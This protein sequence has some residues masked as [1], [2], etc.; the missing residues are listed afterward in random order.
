P[1]LISPATTPQ[2]SSLSLPTSTINHVAMPRTSQSTSP[3]LDKGKQTY[4]PM[5]PARVPKRPAA[6]P[7]GSS[8]VK[9]SRVEL[10]SFTVDNNNEQDDSAEEEDGEKEDVEE[11]VE[12]LEE[13]EKEED[14]EEDEEGGTEDEEEDDGT[15]GGNNKTA[16]DRKKTDWLVAQLCKPEVYLVLQG[17]NPSTTR[18][19]PQSTIHKKL[20][21][22]FT[23]RYPKES[24]MNANAVKNKIASLKRAFRKAHIM[25]T[26]SG[27]GSKDDEDWKRA[28][29]KRFQYYF[30][31]KDN[32]SVAWTDDVPQY[33]DSTANL[34]DDIVAD[35]P[36]QHPQIFP[37][38]PPNAREPIDPI[39]D[40]GSSSQC[41]ISSHTQEHAHYDATEWVDE[42]DGSSLE[43]HEEEDAP[44][45]RRNR[46]VPHRSRGSPTGHPTATRLTAGALPTP[47][48]ASRSIPTG[49]SRMRTPV[50]VRSRRSVTPASAQASRASTSNSTMNNPTNF[51]DL[52]DM[53]RAGMAS[54]HQIREQE[55]ILR[56]EALA[57]QKEET[58]HRIKMEDARLQLERE[59][60]ELEAK[61]RRQQQANEAES[62]RQQQANELAVKMEEIK[63]KREINLKSMELQAELN[64][65]EQRKQLT[66]SPPPQPQQVTTD[67]IPASSSYVSKA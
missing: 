64:R 17:R 60:M 49:A 19:T 34:D 29:K 10:A 41:D 28:I 50:P 62:R 25:A 3:S 16:S 56:R 31:M 33:V 58:E 18:K 9:K 40:P 23:A 20:A 4:T 7:S 11:V 48:H 15:E 32:W 51:N 63:T 38:R 13:K 26:Q 5:R 43:E 1:G 35:D 14:E 22:A 53:F 42:L 21:D 55:L 37:R 54:D 59:R 8:R 52:G 46:T 66:P 61:S 2:L 27:F 6:A 65:R 12:E 39:Q 36:A 44:L 47:P 57:L 67:S 45:L 24:L 30:D